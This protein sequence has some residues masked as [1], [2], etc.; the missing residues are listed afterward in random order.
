MLDDR[1]TL[2]DIYAEDFTPLEYYWDNLQMPV[3]LRQL[4][5]EQDVANLNYIATSP[6]FAARPKEKMKMMNQIMESRGFKKFHGGTNR[7]VY[8]FLE[9]DSFVVKVALDKVGMGD[10]PAEY[11]N[12][13]LLKPFVTRVFD[14]SPCGTIA[15]FERVTPILN[16]E[17]FYSVGNDVFTLL[18]EYILG[19]YV[20]NDIGTNSWMNYGIRRGFGVCLLDFPYV[21]ETSEDKLHCDKI[22]PFTFIPCN[23][24]IDYDDGFNKLI[25]CK[26]GKVYDS[27]EL[28]KTRKIKLITLT[29]KEKQIMK[30][31]VCKGDQEEI[32][33]GDVNKVSTTVLPPQEVSIFSHKRRLREKAEQ[34]KS[35]KQNAYVDNKPDDIKHDTNITEI[36]PEQLS[37]EDDDFTEIQNE[38]E[39]AKEDNHAEEVSQETNDD[40]GADIDDSEEPEPVR[41]VYD[42]F[43]TRKMFNAYDGG[44]TFETNKPSRNNFNKKLDRQ[45]N[46]RNNRSNLD[47][48]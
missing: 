6:R 41:K 10:N 9:D 17:E 22:D 25:C 23:G 2:D 30:V 31:I 47:K 5:S 42:D 29:R 16:R 35:N 21:Y 28:S 44:L 1:Y 14:C 20:L 36:S 24:L 40:T 37:Y 12:Q 46:R 7:I 38:V 27:K 18:T 39:A 8:T 32:F 4:I 3:P 48:F 11:Y 19:Q 34:E 15:A 13:F 45:K 43:R 26:C 33:N